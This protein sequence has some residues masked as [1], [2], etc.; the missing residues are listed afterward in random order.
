M[1]MNNSCFEKVSVPPNYYVGTDRKMNLNA[2]IFLTGIATPFKSL[3]HIMT[4]FRVYVVAKVILDI[5]LSF[6]NKYWKKIHRNESQS[7][8]VNVYIHLS[9]EAC[10]TC[11][12]MGAI[13]IHE[14]VVHRNWN[15]NVK[16]HL[17]Y[18]QG[19]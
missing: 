3:I 6:P 8:M 14:H 2:K 16:A 1:V 9:G 15:M 10:C 13:N 4:F 7:V 11:T 5:S 18:P 19:W 12:F 17:K